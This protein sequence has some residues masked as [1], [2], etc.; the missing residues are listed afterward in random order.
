MVNPKIK[1]APPKTS[2]VATAN[3]FPTTW[4]PK[5]YWLGWGRNW[6]KKKILLGVTMSK[7]F[8]SSFQ[9]LRIHRS[10][11]VGPQIVS[12]WGQYW[13]LR[14]RQFPPASTKTFSWETEL[15]RENKTTQMVRQKKRQTEKV[16]TNRTIQNQRTDKNKRRIKKYGSTVEDKSKM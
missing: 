5:V 2:A 9:L 1:V 15:Y 10:M 13:V 11:F 8:S 14:L 6:K 12:S 7:A 3:A 4:Q 16:Q